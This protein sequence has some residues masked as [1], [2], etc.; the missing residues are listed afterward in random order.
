M[1][2][3]EAEN[4]IKHHLKTQTP[5]GLEETSLDNIKWN[6]VNINHVELCN[7]L[8]KIVCVIQMPDKSKEILLMKI[9]N[10]GLKNMEIALQ[11]AMRVMDVDLYE[12]EGK[13]RVAQFLTKHTP[14]EAIDQ[15]NMSREITNS[16]KNIKA[17]DVNGGTKI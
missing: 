10:P 1:D 5:E 6:K 12:A 16:A 7:T 9:A 4:R 3:Q 11:S 2:R 8:A 14:Q 13:H 17:K 15:F